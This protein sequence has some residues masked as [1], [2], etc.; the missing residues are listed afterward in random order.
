MVFL[1]GRMG[2]NKKALSLI[3]E[4]LGDVERVSWPRS[5]STSPVTT[6]NYYCFMQAIDFA[7]EQNDHDL[8]EDLLKYSETKP[9][10][11]DFFSSLYLYT[12]VR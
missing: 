10:E 7:K 4:R 12:S 11:F 5:S 1:L 2:D 8:W 6:T 9:S 3:I